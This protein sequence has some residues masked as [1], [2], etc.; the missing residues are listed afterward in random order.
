[1]GFDN[2]L[3]ILIFATFPSV[4]TKA[5]NQ[6]ANYIIFIFLAL[7]FLNKQLVSS[8]KT[9]L[10]DNNIDNDNESVDSK[11]CLITKIS[12]HQKD[13]IKYP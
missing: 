9:I 13:K 4:Y 3:L 7:A 11:N 12:R 5:N 1:M 8:I 10:V 2:L 6:Q